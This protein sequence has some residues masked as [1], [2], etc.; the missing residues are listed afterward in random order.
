MHV[1]ARQNQLLGAWKIPPTGRAPLGRSV[2]PAAWAG[3]QPSEQAHLLVLTY[4]LLT[5]GRDRQGCTFAYSCF[6]KAECVE[7]ENQTLKAFEIAVYTNEA[8]WLSGYIEKGTK[9]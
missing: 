3:P 7:E 1:C 9:T 2:H 5:L 6:L 4:S 8:N